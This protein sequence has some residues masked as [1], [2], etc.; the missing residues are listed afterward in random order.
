MKSEKHFYPKL[1]NEI[2]W[3]LILVSKNLVANV[4]FLIAGQPVEIADKD[5]KL[6][7]DTEN[8]ENILER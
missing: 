3:I 5:Q 2:A 1:N 6:Q 7:L 8:N 4:N